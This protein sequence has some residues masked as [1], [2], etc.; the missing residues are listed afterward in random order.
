[1]FTVFSTQMVFVTWSLICAS[2]NFYFLI[3]SAYFLCKFY[4]QVKYHKHMI[5]MQNLA[6]ASLLTTHKRP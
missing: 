5:S 4:V 2:L 1:M 6:R 3:S